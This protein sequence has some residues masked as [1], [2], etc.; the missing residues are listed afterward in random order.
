MS[1]VIK[2]VSPMISAGPAANADK[3]ADAINLTAP[4]VGMNTVVE[5]SIESTG[6][7]DAYEVWRRLIKD[8]RDR[9]K[10]QSSN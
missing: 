1:T 9:R 6:G 7:W 5:P 4:E 10:H 8:A 3:L 2:P